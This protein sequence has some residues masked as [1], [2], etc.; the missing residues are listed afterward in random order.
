MSLGSFQ[1]SMGG[2]ASLAEGCQYESLM[3][4]RGIHYLGR[5]TFLSTPSRTIVLVEA[6]SWLMLF[7]SLFVFIS[8]IFVQVKRT[9]CQVAQKSAE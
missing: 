3:E 9:S 2:P 5:V 1:L 6:I 8:T 4:Q 7:K